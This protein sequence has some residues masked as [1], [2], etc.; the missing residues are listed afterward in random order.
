M[1]EPSGNYVDLTPAENA[2]VN[3]Q[4]WAKDRKSFFYSSNERDENFFDLYEMTIDGFT[5]QM[6]YQN[7]DGLNV[8]AI[9]DDKNYL[10]LV[11]NITTNNSDNTGRRFGPCSSRYLLTGKG[12]SGACSFTCRKV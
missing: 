5:T 12:F 11:K 2:K 6:L 8:S 10:A 4:G 7:N 9:S 1:L 3:F